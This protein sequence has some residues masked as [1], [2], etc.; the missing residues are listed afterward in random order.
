[1]R[2]GRHQIGDRR[3]FVIAEIGNNHN[4]SPAQAESL[5]RAFAA[6]GADAVKFQTFEP[7][8]LVSP[9]VLSNRYP[10]WDVAAQYDRWVDFLQTLVLPRESYP[11]LIAVARD[12]GVAF[13]S[14]ATSP[15]TA[16][17]LADQ[18]VDGIK[19]A[20]MDI[21]NLPLLHHIGA[22]GLPVVVST[23][24]ATIDEIRECAR[25]FDPA[26]LAVLH[27]VSNYPLEHED[28][29]L[30]NIMTL[31]AALDV[32]VGF[33]DHSLGR[34]LPVAAVAMGAC[35][36]EKHVTFDR[37]SPQ[38]AEHHFSMTPDEFADML[39]ALRGVEK[40]LGLSDRVLG[41]G[42]QRSRLE[43]RRSL[44]VTRDIGAGD[45]I[46]PEDVSCVRPGTSVPPRFRDRV[47]GARALR[48]IAAYTPFT[49]EDIE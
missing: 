6:A 12:L 35:I 5:M 42:E 46:A 10:G 30:R 29:N 8:D 14:T 3:T 28:A 43:Y 2:I 37:A 21:D 15:E 34:D 25:C 41:A 36:I 39:K 7:E 49:L 44:F 23:G 32:P 22:L 47:E 16:S 48:P 40:A 20:S 13:M 1:M 31:R 19:V 9:L 11:H 45:R 17:F 18:G 27:C 26:N 38:K 4:G 24:M 33:S